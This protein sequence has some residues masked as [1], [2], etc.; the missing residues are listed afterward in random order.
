MLTSL[1]VYLA[2]SSNPF[3]LESPLP[4]LTVFDRVS[5]ALS[6]AD[7]RLK[8]VVHSRKSDASLF[9]RRKSLYSTT[10]LPAE[11]KAETLNPSFEALLS[12]PIPSSHDINIS[13]AE[14]AS[15]EGSFRSQLEGLSHCVDPYW[16]A[17]S[18]PSGWFCPSR[19]SVV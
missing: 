14:C 13:L 12:K 18:H 5:T 9:P 16:P 3:F 11:G 17:R 10:G 15:L 2:P 4:R 7:D 8:L 19:S 1:L 6:K